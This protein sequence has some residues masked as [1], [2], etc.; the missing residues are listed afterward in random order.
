M[1]SKLKTISFFLSLLVLCFNTNCKKK[2]G[3]I[4]KDPVLGMEFALIRKGSFTMGNLERKDGPTPIQQV[5]ISK[6]YWLGITEVTQGQWQKI[7][8]SQ[9][10]HPDKPSPFLGV[11]SNYP[12]V[13]VSYYDIMD[14]LQK[15]NTL[16]KGHG[17]RF[18]LPTEAEWEYACRANTTSPF[19]YGEI[20]S[21]TLANYN[22]KIPSI[23]SKPG[24]FLEHPMPVKS[25]PPN[26]WGLY[27]MHG[28][29]WEWVSDWYG[30][31][32]NN[33]MTDPIG[34]KNGEE[35]VI[36]GGSWY[37]GAQNAKSSFRK[38]HQPRLWG[39]SIG[40]RV[41]CEIIEK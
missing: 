14:F 11:N 37:F 12:K 10:I 38:P 5:H 25:Y 40:F 34:P 16:S 19:S 20:L 26:P 15:L 24:I 22:A 17:Y 9:E 1:K 6:D 29:V 21:D 36:R 4:I 7:M 35:K 8:G 32:P 33:E 23:Y 3:P 28:N 41:V 13:S 31:Y 30:P 18:R 2:T 39:F 27:D